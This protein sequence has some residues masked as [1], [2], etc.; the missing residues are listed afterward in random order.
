MQQCLQALEILELLERNDRFYRSSEI[1]LLRD[2]VYSRGAK[3][4]FS[5]FVTCLN[6]SA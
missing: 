3:R 6:S 4:P 1:N 2:G 5:T